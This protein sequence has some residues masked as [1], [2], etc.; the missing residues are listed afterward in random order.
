MCT[1]FVDGIVFGWTN[2]RFSTQPG[3]ITFINPMDSM[4]VSDPV[5]GAV[6]QVTNVGRDGATIVN[7]SSTLT[8]NVTS[9][10]F[11]GTRIGCYDITGVG[12]VQTVTLNLTSM[13]II[14]IN[15]GM[16]L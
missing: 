14:N 16:G 4:S 15:V 1:C 6:A 2:D 7:I 12:N 5:T 8:L 9:D 11:D 3:G 13:C 10:L